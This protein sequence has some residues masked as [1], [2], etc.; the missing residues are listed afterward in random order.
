V[1]MR[2]KH[3]FRTYPNLSNLN[4]VEPAEIFNHTGYDSAGH[5]C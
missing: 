4:E 5:A 3:V 2:H 1:L